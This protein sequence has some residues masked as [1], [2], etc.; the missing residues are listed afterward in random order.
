MSLAAPVPR[1]VQPLG[2]DADLCACDDVILLCQDV[3]QL[4]LAFITP[5]G[6]QH[7]SNLGVQGL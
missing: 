4:A 3:H 5:L 1:W 2:R 7:N 6:A